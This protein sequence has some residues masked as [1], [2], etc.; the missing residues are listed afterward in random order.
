MKIEVSDK[1]NWVFGRTDGGDATGAN[2]PVTTMFRGSVPYFIA[3]EP[4]QNIIDAGKVFP[5]KASFDQVSISVL[6]IPRIEQLEK[7]FHACKK[8]YSEVDRYDEDCINFANYVIKKIVSKKRI[9]LLKIGDKNTWGMSPKDYY[10]FMK[11]VGSSSKE[12]QKGGSFGLGKGAYFAASNFRTIFLSTIFYKDN[13]PLFAGKAR[14]V[15]FCENNEVMQSNGTL[16]IARQEPITQV[17]DIPEFFKRSEPGTDIFVVDFDQGENWDKEII[18]SVLVNFWL[19]ILE[20]KLEVSVHDTNITSQNL[21]KL[22]YEYFQDKPINNKHEQNPIPYYEAY[23]N[24]KRLFFDGELDTI[25]SVKLYILIK[26]GYPKHISYIRNTGMVIQ[27]KFHPSSIQY[28]GVFICDNEKA[29]PILRAME[30]PQHDDWS[31]NNAKDGQPTQLAKKVEKEIKKFIREKL[32]SLVT[33]EDKARFSIKGTEDYLRIPF[34]EE[35]DVEK[36]S[37]ESE[38]IIGENESAERVGLEKKADLNF[39]LGDPY[40]VKPLVRIDKETLE[41]LDPKKRKNSELPVVDPKTGK[42]LKEVRNFKARSFAA[43]DEDG[44]CEHI[45]VIRSEPNKKLLRTIVR[46]GSENSLIF[47]PIIHAEN[48]NTGENYKVNGNMIQNIK[49]DNN[50]ICHL[51]IKF[52]DNERY[53]LSIVAYTNENN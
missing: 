25:G 41:N 15:S 35:D 21:D 45:V 34:N 23:T 39:R 12:A 33:S 20:G 28:A 6:D 43:I 51:I 30:N 24:N 13:N 31:A 2:D 8:Y 14:L 37:S 29:A 47:A 18:K 10:N 11:G 19:R 42:P 7:V 9:N 46:I 22:I 27:K 3:R 17:K 26:D 48:K 53:S 16:G 50:G 49:T 40:R 1:I 52:A 5:V 38:D 32:N 4:L 36:Y 44:S